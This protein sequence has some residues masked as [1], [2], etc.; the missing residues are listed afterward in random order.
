MGKVVLI[1]GASRGI[2]RALAEKFLEE[3]YFVIGTSTS[4]KAE[5]SSKNLT[6][7]KLDLSSTKSINACVN[8]FKK[9]NKKRKYFNIW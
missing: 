4:G 6:F 1:T 8:S 5:F 7:L 3:N 9:L 2:G